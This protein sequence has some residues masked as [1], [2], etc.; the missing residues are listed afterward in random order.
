M[1]DVA[2]MEMKMDM[3]EEDV[4]RG[5]GVQSPTGL[6]RMGEGETTA[7]MSLGSATEIAGEE[8]ATVIPAAGA[9]VTGTSAVA[10]APPP[11][12]PKLFDL[13][14]DS[15]T[16]DV[17]SWS[18]D[19]RRFAVH[20]PTECARDILPQYFKHNNFSSFVRQLN[21]YGFHKCDPD[22]WAFEHA[23]FLRGRKE[24]LG[25]ISRR[26]PKGTT[27][28]QSLTVNPESKTVLE[29]G[30]YGI[31]GSEL[32]VLKRD[33]D[34]LLKELMITRHKEHALQK[35]CES[36]EMRINSL[37]RNTKQMQN[38]IYH[39]FNQ[40]IQNYSGAVR[41]R[42]RLTNGGSDS[43]RSGD[44]LLNSSSTA[45]LQ[46]ANVGPGGLHEDHPELENIDIG[47]LQ[48]AVRQTFDPDGVSDGAGRNSFHAFPAMADVGYSNPPLLQNGMTTSPDLRGPPFSNLIS[49]SKVNCLSPAS[50]G[51][52][53]SLLGNYQGSTVREVEISP[54]SPS[55][56]AS[57]QENRSPSLAAPMAVGHDAAA[58]MLGM[59]RTQEMT[60]PSEKQQSVSVIDTNDDGNEEFNYELFD[61]P[62]AEFPPLQELPTGTDIDALTR[63][64]EEFENHL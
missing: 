20:K 17:V 49:S 59:K 36:H 27:I 13:V 52:S 61:Y 24:L 31:L 14:S 53:P 44:E 28:L 18:E 34:L 23:S 48:R 41:K 40:V 30:N 11:F 26:K 32:E 57:L 55:P 3:K 10:G 15:K 51:Y 25:G 29:L 60:K 35:L 38:F 2:T 8:K 63:Q 21:Q 6:G 5:P 56:A 42:K 37:E 45:A 7:S 1:V 4:G 46:I 64:L 33:K 58:S 43:Q 47:A 62:I 39:Y 9:G 22:H 50:P 16:D 19:G 54:R 12:L